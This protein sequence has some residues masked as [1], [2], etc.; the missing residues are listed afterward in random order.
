MLRSLRV[1]ALGVS[2]VAA[3]CSDKDDDLR[4]ELTVNGVSLT[5]AEDTPIS[6]GIS[7][8]GQVGTV[9][10]SVA[11]EPTHGTLVLD[12]STFVYTPAANYAGA[13]SAVVEVSDGE[14]SV[15]ATVSITITPVNDAPT[16]S[17]TPTLVIDED[18]SIHITAANLGV[19]DIDNSTSQI[20]ITI[21]NGGGYLVSDHDIT[22]LP[23][24]A[25]SLAV[26]VTISDGTASVDATLTL[27]VTPVNDA[28]DARVPS[29]RNTGSNTPFTF[30]GDATVS[31]ADIDA[32]TMAVTLSADHGAIS[33][34][35]TT[36]LAFTAGDGDEDASMTFSGA[37]AG[38]NAALAGMVVTPP[39]GFDELITLTI[40]ADD[41]GSTGGGGALTDT[42]TFSVAVDGADVP[43]FNTIPD[44]VTVDEEAT[45]TFQGVNVI[46]V[47]DGNAPGGATVAVELAVTQG[48]LTLAGITG[49][50]FTVGDGTD[51]AAASFSGTFADVNAALGGLTYEAPTNYAGADTLTLTTTSNGLSD[52]DNCAITVAAV[53]DAPE[54]T[55]PA[56]PMDVATAAVITFADANAVVLA[57]LDAGTA[58]VELTVTATAGTFTFTG[59]PA[60][61]ADTSTPGEVVLTG[62]LAQFAADLDML[63]WNAGAFSGS[64]TLTFVI[65]DQAATG[66]GGARTDSLVLTV[67]VAAPGLVASSDSYNVQGN[68]RRV[69]AAPGV[70]VNDSPLGASVTTTTTTSTLGGAVTMSADGGFTY[71]PPTGAGARQVEGGLDDSFTYDI[72]SPGGGTA[73]GTVNLK[74]FR[75]IWFVDKDGAGPTQD[76]S[77][78]APFDTIEEAV[79]AAQTS[80]YGTYIYVYDA[81]TAYTPA[82]MTLPPGTSVLSSH[83]A[84]D[85]QDGTEP[86][87][88]GEAILDG[89]ASDSTEL[90]ALGRPEIIPAGATAFNLGD[91]SRISGFDINPGA[92]TTGPAIAAIALNSGVI[93]N[94]TIAGFTTGISIVDTTTDGLELNNLVITDANDA[95]TVQTGRASGVSVIASVFERVQ[96]GLVVNATATES[97]ARLSL[98]VIATDVSAASQ[99]AVVVD[100]ETAVDAVFPSLIRIF[101][102]TFV[103]T[104]ATGTSA[105]DIGV[106]GGAL[107]L[108]INNVD[109]GG[110][111]NGLTLDVGGAQ[112]NAL[113]ND[114]DLVSGSFASGGYQVNGLAA[115]RL[116]LTVRDVNG[117]V[118]G[119]PGILMNSNQLN[120][121]LDLDTSSVS[122]APF[123]LVLLQASA[124]FELE[125]Y[126]GGD[127]P[128]YF[129]TRFTG[130][131]GATGT[132]S[133][134]TGGV[135]AEPPF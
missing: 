82:L 20:S 69:V 43:P 38:V 2:L 99:N 76:G 37:F 83:V 18:T 124:A 85:L 62:T 106:S 112:V 16:V 1:L 98:F 5:T 93:D 132:Y 19:S 118:S 67:N 52:T 24:L 8:T 49:L 56:S 88:E 122:G 125:G 26:P 21:A 127:V 53:N 102:S 14:K 10:V 31:I 65:D 104:G 28:P 134:P 135:C 50:S 116:D 89:Y 72:T 64:A 131:V 71:V 105:I 78:L 68:V 77:F 119:V 60:F 66:S 117:A 70:L 63:Q 94:V 103:N 96:R 133:T 51:D 23:N 110:Y 54:I 84:F 29:P 97:N 126:V 79:T 90:P 111:G 123:G 55:G 44:A 3:A 130:G 9:R 36:G 113:L 73:S 47:A 46:S 108:E 61:T 58:Q 128:A 121:C 7:A 30:T 91:T 41:Q 114:V 13:D 100:S 57:D 34:S 75:V 27:T 92:T 129:S 6:G 86:P 39:N 12:D 59:T 15:T 25:G 120:I 42:E 74:I 4:S 22:P 115:G 45:L 33:L 40:I 107:E 17:A 11:Q 32:A 48:V 101:A 35:T 87:L 95:I 80:H 81:T 109:L